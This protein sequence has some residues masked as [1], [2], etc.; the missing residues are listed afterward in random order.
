MD[1]NNIKPVNGTV[2]VTVFKNYLKDDDSSYARVKR[3]TA[4][5]NH[6]VG[7]ILKTSTLMDKATLV[8][9]QML[10]KEA[11]LDLLKQG[12]AVNIFDLGTLY[13][14]AQ[15][16]IESLNPSVED[17]PSLSLS[18]TPSAEALEA[19]KGTDVSV[20]ILAETAPV[21][22]EIEDLYEHKTDCSVTSGRAVRIT[23]RRLKIAGDSSKAGLF[24]AAQD[25]SGEIS[26]DESTWLKVEDALFFKNTSTY[27]EFTL[28]ETLE[29]GSKYSLIIRTCS[30]RGS[31]VNKTVRELVYEK[32]LTV[33][34]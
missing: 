26:S 30:G 14:S 23:G 1:T 34:L 2:S 6:V 33:N 3:T 25:A 12:T 5:M 9:A 18:F 29:K 27:L 10:F 7:T 21:I 16:N 13:P 24:F 11:I 8:A 17:I 22:T 4:G 19:V 15:G 28:P 20:A 31:K 32:T